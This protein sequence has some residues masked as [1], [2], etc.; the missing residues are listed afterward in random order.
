MSGYRLL[1]SL[2]EHNRRRNRIPPP[3]RPTAPY[4]ST[5]LHQ[6]TAP[7]QQTQPLIPISSLPEQRNIEATVTENI[8][9]NRFQAKLSP[10]G[11]GTIQI[12]I[13]E[14][15]FPEEFFEPP[16]CTRDFIHNIAVG[17]LI[18]F[19]HLPNQDPPIT[20]TSIQKRKRAENIMCC[21]IQTPEIRNDPKNTPIA[22]CWSRKW[23]TNTTLKSDLKEP[24]IPEMVISTGQD[25]KSIFQALTNGTILKTQIGINPNEEAYHSIQ[26]VYQIYTKE[27][28]RELFTN[29]RATTEE[30]RNQHNEDLMKILA[31]INGYETRTNNE[32]KERES[33]QVDYRIVSPFYQMPVQFEFQG[34]FEGNFIK[35]NRAITWHDTNFTGKALLQK[36]GNDANILSAT[37]DMDQSLNFWHQVNSHHFGPKGSTTLFPLQSKTKDK[38]EKLIGDYLEGYATSAIKNPSNYAGQMCR[39]AFGQITQLPEPYEM[40]KEK[41]IVMGHPLKLNS[42]IQQFLGA[43]LEQKSPMA[44]MIGPPGTGK[45]TSAKLL[46]ANYLMKYPDAKILLTGP[47]NAAVNVLQ[48]KVEELNGYNGLR[49]SQVRIIPDLQDLDKYESC[50]KFVPANFCWEHQ[51]GESEDLTLC[52]EEVKQLEQDLQEINLPDAKTPRRDEFINE[53]RPRI[54]DLKEKKKQL[55]FLATENKNPNIYAST[56]IATASELFAHKKFDLIIGDELAQ[57]KTADFLFALRLSKTLGQF[58]GFGD[59]KQLPPLVTSKG[60]GAEILKYTPA[61]LFLSLHSVPVF[62]LTE[63][64][65]CPPDLINYTSQQFYNQTVFSTIPRSDRNLLA[66]KLELHQTTPPRIWINSTQPEVFINPGWTNPAEVDITLELIKR[67]T[68][69]GIKHTDIVILTPYRAQLELILH[70]KPKQ[71]GLYT[72]DGFQGQESPIMILSLVR[73]Q[74]RLQSKRP[75]VR[76]S[77][78]STNPIGFLDDERRINVATS[79]QRDGMFIIGNAQTLYHTNRYWAALVDL[80]HD[81]HCIVENLDQLFYHLPSCLH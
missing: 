30:E 73:S 41:I 3:S 17:D 69:I 24:H 64:F 80:V 81:Y 1:E 35:A 56:M 66:S 2:E 7:Y 54:K 11:K 76:N 29:S 46:V 70:R 19:Q 5:T 20:I 37:L 36:T 65:R 52:R 27:D 68:S 34:N 45:S 18:T 40:P 28:W 60:E 43:V 4:Q 50:A 77:P 38:T 6:P 55:E 13:T 49:I 78:S 31:L 14:A 25:K 39:H 42:P 10:S 44:M 33:R 21:Y 74:P 59:N 63:C 8:R 62:Q 9:R 12:H 23:K 32:Y 72:V 16:P 26:R 79:R 71:V 75:I 67:L 48:Q 53:I 22:L 51:P 58:A 61:D 47:S 57:G 15:N